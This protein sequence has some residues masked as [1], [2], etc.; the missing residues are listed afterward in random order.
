MVFYKTLAKSAEHAARHFLA[1]AYR[2]RRFV[3]E[4]ALA[5]R[6]NTSLWLAKTYVIPAGM[7]GSQVWGTGFLQAG[8]EFYSP[9][10]TLHLHF[11]KGTLGVKHSTTNW[12]VLRECKHEPLQFYW[13]Q[14]AVKLIVC[15]IPIVTLCGG[16]F[17][18]ISIYSPVQ[19][20]AGQLN[21]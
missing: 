12:A 13:F 19:V 18:L 5:D 8:R 10:S 6:P 15:L 7:Y 17:R 2:I 4:H 20:P 21:C 9:L 14:S 3:R 16:W 1:S 11:L